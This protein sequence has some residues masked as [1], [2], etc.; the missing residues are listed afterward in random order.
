MVKYGG[1][2]WCGVVICTLSKSILYSAGNPGV[3]DSFLSV[4][5]GDRGLH[6]GGLGS[7]GCLPAS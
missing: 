2:V 4:Q 1:V 5:L 6:G 7:P 3:K